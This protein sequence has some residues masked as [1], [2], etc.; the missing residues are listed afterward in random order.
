VVG[1]LALLPMSV[2]DSLGRAAFVLSGFVLI[3]S[4]M[5]LF[6]NRLLFRA[7]PEMLAHVDFPGISVIAV[8]GRISFT[9]EQLVLYVIL[10]SAA[11]IVIRERKGLARQLGVLLIPQL[12]CAAL[13]YFSLPIELAWALSVLLV[14]L[15]GIE[16]FGLILIRA[17]SAGSFARKRLASE[18]VFF[19]ALGLSFFFPLYYRVS[20]LLGTINVGPLPFGIGAYTAGVYM[21][22]AASLAAFAYAL[23][24][25]PSAGFKANA[26]NF[27]KAAV[28]PTLLVFPFLYG[29]MQSFLMTQIF[30]L[31]IAMSTDIALDFNM[32][33]V[34]T[35]F[36]W[37]LLTSIIL[38]F[39]KGRRS[40]DKFLLQQG[41]GLVL[42]LSTTFLFNY[43]NYL[44]L[45]TT[46]VLLLSYPLLGRNTS[47]NAA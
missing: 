5:D 21:I 23:L 42:I 20:I 24:V 28:V 13:L 9:F 41:M 35:V 40:G 7:G 4:L 18:R 12:G 10:G 36:W 33:R 47:T 11:V 26:I 34:I 25:A 17:S 2:K 1:S 39:L 37:F 32:V 38:L 16:V 29:L 3:T 43:P 30:S 6:V 31:V 19:L 8:I 15:T 45:G 46:G 14:V 22:M 27:A 44:L